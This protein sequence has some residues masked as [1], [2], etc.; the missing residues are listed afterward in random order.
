[1]PVTS[2]QELRLEWLLLD[3]VVLPHCRRRMKGG[4]DGC[5]TPKIEPMLT[6]A[7]IGLIR[8]KA[9]VS[10]DEG[11]TCNRIR[12]RPHDTEDFDADEV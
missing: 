11:R 4:V 5:T 8:L 2:D 9:V 1:M 3:L 10:P 6:T 12:M 7:N